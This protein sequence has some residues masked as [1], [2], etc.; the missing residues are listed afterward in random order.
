M[1]SGES[2]S[3]LTVEGIGPLL[4]NAFG[5]I[6]ELEVQGGLTI[7]TGHVVAFE[8]SSGLLGRQGGRKLGIFIPHQ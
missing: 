8:D 5:T 7:D 1:L 3:F 2:L 4:V 6:T